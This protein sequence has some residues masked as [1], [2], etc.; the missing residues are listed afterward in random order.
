MQEEC[1]NYNDNNFL[2][3]K[4]N[5]FVIDSENLS[6]VKT[7]LYGFSIQDSGIYNEQNRTEQAMHN[8]NGNGAQS[9]WQRGLYLC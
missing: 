3:L 8:L 2:S 4:N 5:F 6:S 1:E 9:Q 7:K